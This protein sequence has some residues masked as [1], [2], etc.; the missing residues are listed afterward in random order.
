MDFLLSRLA[1]LTAENPT[2]CFFNPPATTGDI[3]RAETQL[4]LVLPNS[5][6]QFLANFNGGFISLVGDFVGA[7]WDRESAAWNS[8]TFLGLAELVNAYQ[9]MRDNWQLDLNW[10]GAWPYIPFCHTE[11]QEFLVFSQIDAKTPESAVLDAFHE[12]W[13]Q[14]WKILYPDFPALLED[15]IERKGKIRLVG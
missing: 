1:S 12:I 2:R 15:Y 6:K 4:N 10:P 9:E 7:P 5:Y 3:A 13:P 8:N 14:E 11:G